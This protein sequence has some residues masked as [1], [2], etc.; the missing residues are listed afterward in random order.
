MVPGLILMLTV[1][2]TQVIGLITN[3]RVKALLPMH[4]ENTSSVLMWAT[5]KTAK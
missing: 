4:R 5:G 1:M 2:F 3:V